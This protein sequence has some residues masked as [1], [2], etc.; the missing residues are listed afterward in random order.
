MRLITLSVGAILALVGFV[1]GVASFYIIDPGHVGVEVLGGN[2][3]TQHSPGWGFANPLSNIIGFDC[4][5]KTLDF[6]EV[7]IRS[8]DQMLTT[9][10]ISVQYSGTP[11]QASDMVAETGNLDAVVET[12][13][14][15]KFR[16]AARD[17]GR[18]VV[19]SKEFFTDETQAM[20]AS[21]ILTNLQAFCTPRGLN[22]TDVLIRAIDPPA[23]IEEA[24]QRREEREQ[25]TAEQE[26]ELA[27]FKVEQQ[28][29][30]A[31]ATAE[32]DAALLE[33]EQIRALAAA[34]ADAVA[35][36][37]KAIAENPLVLRLEYIQ[38]WDGVLPKMMLG[39]NAN[40]LLPVTSD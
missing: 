14:V 38:A 15:P 11:G 4:R 1:W 10:E 17:A 6:T 32:R 31:A 24:V 30:I 34:E 9:F 37:G 18:T 12:H 20:V 27:R 22:V 23:F 33:A 21:S 13:L 5:Q 16:S 25:A 40:V 3:V 7:E 19:D 35:L 39:E 29:K 8:Q 36:R 28:Q 26:G 2:V